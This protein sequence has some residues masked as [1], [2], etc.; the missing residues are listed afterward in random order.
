MLRTQPVV[1]TQVIS[2]RTDPSRR[3]SQVNAS[4]QVFF[5]AMV[6]HPEAQK[7]AQAELDAIV[8]RDRLPQI[9][10]LDSLPYFQAFILEV[11]RWRPI[12]GLG[13]PHKTRCDDVFHGYTIPKGSLIFASSW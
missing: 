10:D 5:L 8:G 6:L 9:T 11:L 2:N 4:L 7:N 1:T 3:I 13:F 12:I